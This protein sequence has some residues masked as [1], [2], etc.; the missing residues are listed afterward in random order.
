[1]PR[2]GQPRVVA[3]RNRNQLM[4]R[5]SK[6]QV[7]DIRAM[8]SALGEPIMQYTGTEKLRKIPLNGA[9][10]KAIRELLEQMWPQ[11]SPNNNPI[12]IIEVGKK[13]DKGR[14][15]SVGPGRSTPSVFERRGKER[16]KPA[17][18]SDAD[19]P[20]RLQR[21][22]PNVPGASSS[23]TYPQPDATV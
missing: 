13:R 19:E 23:R 7:D 2:P 12:R 17:A 3:D 14:A 21:V 5:G 9:N 1:T 16:A 8:L 15:G 22:N 6:K 11:I 20:P 18:S 10:S 4:V